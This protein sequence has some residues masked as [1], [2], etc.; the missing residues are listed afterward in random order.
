M[1]YSDILKDSIPTS[2]AIRQGVYVDPDGFCDWWVRSP[3]WY[4][5]YAQTNSLGSG[6]EVGNDEM[7]FHP[8]VCP[9]IWIDLEP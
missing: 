4:Q 6:Y 3:G 8:G 1:K 5:S 2:Y 9:A 7:M